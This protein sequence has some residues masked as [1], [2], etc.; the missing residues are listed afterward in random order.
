MKSSPS[1]DTIE[2]IILAGGENS[3]YDGKLKSKIIINDR[4]ILALMLDVLE[5]VFSTITLSTNS[6]AEFSDFEKINKVSDKHKGIGPLGGIHAAMSQSS[7]EALFVIAGD[8]PYPSESLIRQ[9]AD[10]YLA[11]GC[12]ILIPVY[13]ERIEPLHALYSNS[14]L[15][16]LDHFLSRTRIYSIR[17]FLKTSDVMYFDIGELGFDKAVFTNINT[18]EDF[19]LL[20]LEKIN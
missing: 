11:C 12:E 7:A 5:S 9:M 20:G 16:K 2:G 4:P 13:D 15:K 8:M 1:Y 6:P 10:Y 14:L 19:D 17:E 18:P 3:R